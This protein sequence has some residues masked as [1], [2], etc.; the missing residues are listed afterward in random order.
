MTTKI[1]PTVVNRI[2]AGE[3]LHRP[4]NAVKELMENRSQK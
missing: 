1:D 3:I 4:Y 2:A